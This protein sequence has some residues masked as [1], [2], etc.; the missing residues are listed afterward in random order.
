MTTV[1]YALSPEMVEV[2]SWGTGGGLILAR[3]VTA[4]LERMQLPIPLPIHLWIDLDWRVGI[5]AAILTVVATVACP[6][7]F[8]ATPRAWWGPAPLSAWP[9]RCSRPDR[10]RCFWCP[11]SSRAIR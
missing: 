5:Y 11:G 8:W 2:S 7:L 9:S 4:S 3:A 10:W 6:E 1:S